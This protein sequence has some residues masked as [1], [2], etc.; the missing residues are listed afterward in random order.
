MKIICVGLN[1]QSHNKEMNRAPSDKDDAP[2]LFIKP[3]SALLTGK[4]QFYIPDFSS[5]I[6]YETELVVRID[7]MGKNIAE[8]FAHRYY[9]EVTL[10]LD[11]TARDLQ[12]EL[13]K[14]GLPWEISKAFDNSAVVGTFIAKNELVKSVDDLNFRLEK[15]NVVVQSANTSEMI[16]SVDKIIAYASRF[17]TLKTGDLIFTGTPAGVDSVKIGDHLEGILE[18]NKLFDIRVC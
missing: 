8:R 3:D 12:A 4:D 16:H 13:K 17:F 14:K 11:F 18:N 1:Y 5:D 10:G 7:K 2:V 15:D 6:H 9:N